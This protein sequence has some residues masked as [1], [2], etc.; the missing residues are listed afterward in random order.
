MSFLQDC[1]VSVAEMTVAT[2]VQRGSK[3]VTDDYLGGI[4]IETAEWNGSSFAGSDIERQQS[5]IKVCS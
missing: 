1:R 5:D 3:S 2:A 4:L